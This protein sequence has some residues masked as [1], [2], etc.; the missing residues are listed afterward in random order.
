MIEIPKEFG[1]YMPAEWEKHSAVWLAWPYGDITFPNILDSIEKTY[2]QII[3]ALE[4]SE[5]VKLI[6][7][8]NFEKERIEKILSDYGIYLNNIIFFVQDYAD[9][10]TRDYAP[11]TLF[12]KD[13]NKLGFIK[14]N[15][16]GYGK[17]EDPLFVDLLKDDKVFNNILDKSKYKVFNPEVVLEG[18]A[19]ESNGKGTLLTTEQCLL[20][21]NRENELDMGRTEIYLKAYLGVEKVIWL[22]EGLVN[23]HTDGHIDE[24]ARFVGSNK[25]LCAYEKDKKDPNYSILINNF[26]VLKKS[27]D[28]D[29]KKFKVIK[30]PMPHVNYDNGEKAPVSYT[31]FY[32]GNK[33]VLISVFND[34]NDKKAIKIIKSLFKK[35]KII[36]IDCSKL[37]YGGGA[38]H[39]I[40]MQDYTK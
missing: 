32:I 40:T 29:G 6:V 15:Y 26:K 17:K 35:H 24:I 10:W 39:C 38:I 4:E 28:K 8:N 25:I 27:R 1:Y 19:I 20:N 21:P 3:K 36:P 13:P 2:C 11:I 7:L 12:N 30:L 23:D 5:K 9:V 34:P 22:K 37:I 16:N 18:G 33:V 14:W 31:N